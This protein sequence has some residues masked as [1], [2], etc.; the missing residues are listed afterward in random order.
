MFKVFLLSLPFFV[1]SFPATA[2]SARLGQDSSEA[3]LAK[4]INAGAVCAK[5]TDPSALYER[6]ML[7]EEDDSDDAYLAAA[8]CLTSAA[9][10]NHTDAQIELGKLYESGKG[11]SAS[12]VFAYKW[13]Q[14]AVLLGNERAVPLRNKIEARMNLDEISLA[15]P[16]IQSTLRLIEAYENHRQQEIAKYEKDVDAGRKFARWSGIDRLAANV[17]DFANKH[18]KAF[19]IIVFGFVILSFGMNVYRMGCVWSQGGERKSAVEQQDEMM[20]NRHR[21]IR[22]AVSSA[23]CMPPSINKEFNERVTKINQDNGHTDAKED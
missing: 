16:M 5:M 10:R 1:Q 19:L 14:T 18:T 12:D 15:N 17:Q 21:R 13:F 23:H 6:A 4:Y 8:E 2:Q 22:K 11:V 7:L 20:K 3:L 9:M